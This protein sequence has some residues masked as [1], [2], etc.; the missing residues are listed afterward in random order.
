MAC[1]PWPQLHQ[2]GHWWS[3]LFCEV[4]HY[5][6]FTNPNILINVTQCN[7]LSRQFTNPNSW[8][9]IYIGP[10]WPVDIIFFTKMHIFYFCSYRSLY[11]NS[12]KISDNITQL[13]CANLCRP[14][15]N[16][17]GS[18][19]VLEWLCIKGLLCATMRYS[20]YWIY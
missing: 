16:W 20:E 12:F 14:K 8:N 1:G 6:T 7:S 17:F 3:I 18:G 5:V 19:M 9:Y 15:L 13:C 10:L 4:L 11:K 2:G